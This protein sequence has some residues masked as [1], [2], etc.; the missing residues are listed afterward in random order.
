MVYYEMN[1]QKLC[2]QLK[3]LLAPETLVMWL[4]AMPVSQ[5]VRGGFL[6]EEI[7]FV[8]EILR[9]DILLANY[10]ANQVSYHRPYVVTSYFLSFS[11]PC[12]TVDQLCVFVCMYYVTMEQN[13]R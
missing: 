11:W 1:L 6:N 4:T 13:D 5:S 10:Y 2:Y 3:R 9:L 7:S 8:N 12:S